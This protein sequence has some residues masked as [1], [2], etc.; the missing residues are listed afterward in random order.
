VLLRD[1]R[2]DDLDLY[3]RMYCDPVMMAQLGGPQPRDWMPEKLRRHV[4]RAVLDEGW[5]SVIVPDEADPAIV[6]GLVSLYRNPSGVAEI[7]W[8]VLTEFQRRG[9]GRAAVRLLLDRAARDGRWGSVHAYPGVGNA[10]SNGI[11]RSLGFSLAG[12]KDSTYD[13]QTFR[14]NDWVIEP[15]DYGTRATAT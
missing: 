12:E 8:A 2:T 3:Y 15:P 13:G 7:G 10:G 11:C 4:G 1:V 5:S 9:I 6:A 14:S